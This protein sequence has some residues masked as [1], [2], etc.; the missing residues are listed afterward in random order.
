MV[1]TSMDTTDAP[2]APVLR[3]KD[4]AAVLGD[5]AEA[6]GWYI[7]S[8]RMSRMIAISQASGE[9]LS[10]HLSTDEHEPKRVRFGTEDAPGMW[11]MHEP[12]QGL[13]KQFWSSERHRFEAAD[14]D[15]AYALLIHIQKT[16]SDK[17]LN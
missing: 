4:F 16:F 7:T 13:L 1:H 5:P 12:A 8:V 2:R 6:P 14:E 17:T 15:E 9:S 3:T 10:G 11:L